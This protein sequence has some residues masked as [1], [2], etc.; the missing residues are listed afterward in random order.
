M[1]SIR[2]SKQTKTIVKRGVTELITPGVTLNDA[3]LE[4]KTNNYLSAVFKLQQKWA[5]AFVDVSTSNFLIASGDQ[6]YIDKL[7]QNFNPTEILYAKPQ[8]SALL[9]SWISLY[10]LHALED[11]ILK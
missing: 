9:D 5:V 11:W 2:R 10:H 3:I 7:L 6:H 4:Q 1:R 8:K